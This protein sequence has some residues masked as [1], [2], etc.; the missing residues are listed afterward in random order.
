MALDT[1]NLNFDN[2]G[3]EEMDV[4]LQELEEVNRL[5]KTVYAPHA[6]QREFHCAPHKRRGVFGGN[7]SGKTEVGTNEARFHATGNYPSWYPEKLRWTG[8]T[9]GRIVVTDYK[10]GCKEVFEPKFNQW[11][12]PEEIEKIERDRATG[13]LSKV[14]VKHIS[15]GISTFDIMTHEQDPNQFEGWSGH[16]VWFDEPPPRDKYIAC[17]RGLVDF[18]GR[19][20]I[21]ATPISEPWLYDE[22]IVDSSLDVWHIAVSMYDNPYITREAIDEFVKSLTP[23]EKE[24]RLYGKFLHLS[25]RVYGE[26]DTNVHCVSELPKGHEYWPIYFVLDPADRR[27]HHGIWAKVDPFETIWVFDEIVFKGTI[28]DTSKEILK[29]EVTHKINPLQVIRILDPNKGN[30]PSSVTGLRLVDEFAS[31][32]VYFI[33]TVN[34]DLALGHLAVKEKLAYDRNEPVSTTNHPKL[35][36]L[37]ERT[38]ECIKQ[39]LSYVWDDWRGR[40]AAGKSQKEKPKDIN[41]DMPDC[42]RYL[43][44]SNPVFYNPNE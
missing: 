5:S 40:D 42:I 6:K 31:H 32:A 2:L 37:R 12:L 13:A 33:A 41:K 3:P 23:E 4:L 27:P 17:L 9:R 25:G 28:K 20:W 24:A 16:W 1:P 35:F 38:K 39:L 30:T 7:R 11:F 22:F 18:N 15:G 14:Y 36:F 21:T 44:M 34:D 8:P 10:K 19:L 29:R 26:L 43:C